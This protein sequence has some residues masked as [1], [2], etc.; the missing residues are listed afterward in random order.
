MGANIR[1]FLGAAAKSTAEAA[2]LLLQRDAAPRGR[3][4]GR[5]GVGSAVHDRGGDGSCWGSCGFLWVLF[6]DV[7]CDDCYYVCGAGDEF[8]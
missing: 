3:S 1:S 6:G 5:R 7:G 8:A 4:W 2:G